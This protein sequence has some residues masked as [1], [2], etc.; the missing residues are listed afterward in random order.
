MP[1]PANLP[2]NPGYVL[3]VPV[4]FSPPSAGTVSGTYRFTFTDATGTHEVDVPL[5]GTGAAATTGTVAIPPP[6]GGWTFNGSAQM[7]SPSVTLNPNNTAEAGSVVYSV[8]QP[9]DGLLANFTMS[10]GGDA[11][12]EGMTLALLDPSSA[13][14]TALGSSGPGLGWAGQSGVAVALVTNS[15]SDEPSSP[16]VGIAT[17]SSGG[18][19]KFAATSTTNVP[20]LSTGTHSV[21]V[22]VSGQTITV[23]IDSQQ[24]LSTTLPCRD[25]SRERAGR[26]HR[27][28]RQRGQPRPQ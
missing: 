13:G 7:T 9:S 16:F 21:Q 14:L 8:P 27:R 18:Q 28:D 19:P 22:S 26:L 17:G 10:I 15:A 3:N 2:V 4:T 25:H 20:D 6:G 23:D 11:D 12:A 1:V 5:S 24:A